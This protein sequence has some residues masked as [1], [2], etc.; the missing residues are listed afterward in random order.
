VSDNNQVQSVYIDIS[1]PTAGS[2][3]NF[4]M[5]DLGTGTFSYEQAYDMLGTYTCTIWAEDMSGNPSSRACSFVVQDTTRPLITGPTE[6]PQPQNVGGN[7]NV[8]ALITDNFQMLIVKLVVVDPN[9]LPLGNTTMS[10]DAAS[11]RYYWDSAY[12]TVGTYDYNIFA[13]DTSSNVGAYTGAFAIDDMVS[14]TLT[15][16]MA[17]PDPQEVYSDVSSSGLPTRQATGELTA[18]HS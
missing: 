12:V 2:V 18:A 1:D 10:F 3:G 9:S 14:P 16:T 5:I 11:G 7:V 8:S 15:I 13:W 17:T 4:S 6:D